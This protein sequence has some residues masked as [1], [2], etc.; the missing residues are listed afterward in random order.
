MERPPSSYHPLD[1][2]RLPDAQERK[3][4][5]QYA[6]LYFVR[7]ALLKHHVERVAEE[8]WSDYEFGGE[9]ARRVER[10]LDVR[11][12]ELCWVVGTVFMDMVLKPNILDDLAQEVRVGPTGEAS[13]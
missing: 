2:F 12:G 6:D 4:T 3:Y 5:T 1:T 10:V 9:K 7:L 11:Q 8:A 13:G